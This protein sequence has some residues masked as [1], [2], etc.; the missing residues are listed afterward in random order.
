M[1]SS[2]TVVKGMHAD[3]RSQY[4]S[5]G[6]LFYHKLTSIHNN[7]IYDWIQYHF[8]YPTAETRIQA[9]FLLQHGSSFKTG[10]LELTMYQ[11][12]NIHNSYKYSTSLHWPLQCEN[13]GL[14]IVNWLYSLNSKAQKSEGNSKNSSRSK[15]PTQIINKV[16]LLWNSKDGKWTTV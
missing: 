6:C 2:E 5:T 12:S 7:Y 15:D 8:N 16:Q 11:K 1:Q 4:V 10:P 3:S 14:S 9:C 13:E